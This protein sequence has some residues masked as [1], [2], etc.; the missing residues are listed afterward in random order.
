MPDS[1]ADRCPRVLFAGGGSGGHLYPA[2]AVADELV[3]QT[4]AVCEFIGSSRPVEASILANTAYR[5]HVVD[6]VIGSD[7]KRQPF[8]SAA[9]LWRGIRKAGKMLRE[10][11]PD[12]VVGCGGFASVPT[13]LAAKLRLLPVVLLEQNHVPGTATRLLA[14]LSRVICAP[15]EKFMLLPRRDVHCVLTGNPVRQEIAKLIETPPDALL[16]NRL[17]VVLGGSQGSRRINEAVLAAWQMFSPPAGWRVLHLAGEVDRDFVRTAYDKLPIE[18]EVRPFHPEIVSVWRDAALVVCRG[19][20]STLAELACAGVPAI[21]I[22]ILDSVHDHQRVNAAAYANAGAA[23]MLEE[24]DS[25]L[26]QLLAREL[27]AMI[28]SQAERRRMILAQ[29]T[30]ARP[31]AAARVADQIVGLIKG[32]MHRKP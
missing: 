24:N 22:P 32:R 1:L 5:H 17:I 18:A 26:P 16:S 28:D 23:R 12:V 15:I 8:A 10:F 9:T 13:V 7:F 2:I 25:R 11:R 14:P 21:V 4:E 29:R 20:A 30:V 6:T 19:G 31:Q 27:Q 3:R